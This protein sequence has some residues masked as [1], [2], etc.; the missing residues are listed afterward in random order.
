M[1]ITTKFWG[2]QGN[3]MMV[4]QKTGRGAARKYLEKKQ[5]AAAIWGH[6]S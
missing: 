3:E 2:T 5:V 6:H 4:N 1:T